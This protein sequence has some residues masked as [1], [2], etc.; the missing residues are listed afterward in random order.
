VNKTYVAN[1]AELTLAVAAHRPS[2]SYS[3]AASRSH[4]CERT[5]DPERSRAGLKRL[6]FHIS[7][8][9]TAS[10][11]GELDKVTSCEDHYDD[12]KYKRQVISSLQLAEIS[13]NELEEVNYCG[14]LD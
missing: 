7:K 8:H 3:I 13:C 12:Y 4:V 1:Y 6:A 2:V 14:C 11:T 5:P 10:T 9:H